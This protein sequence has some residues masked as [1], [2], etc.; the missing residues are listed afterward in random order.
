MFLAPSPP[1]SPLKGEGNNDHLLT[2]RGI[3]NTSLTPAEVRILIRAGALDSLRGDQTRPE[4]L[5]LLELRERG[6]DPGNIS[7]P[8]LPE[9]P[10][11]ERFRAEEETLGF[12]TSTHPLSFWREEIS[13]IPHCPARELEK[14]VGQAVTLIGIQIT[15]K[16]VLSGRG[17]PMSFVTFEDE[18]GL[19]ETVL[20]PGVF[21]RDG[22]LLYSPGPFAIRGKV[23]EEFGAVTVNVQ[24]LRLLTKTRKPKT[25]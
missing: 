1:P 24:G 25:R 14:K 23:E 16:D 21:R 15:R 19:V 4:L 6:F 10:P 3:Q 18:T 13:R 2:E 20:F 8:R 7:L 5:L 22:Y 17:E 9:Y 12:F 11:A